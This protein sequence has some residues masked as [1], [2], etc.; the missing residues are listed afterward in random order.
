MGVLDTVTIYQGFRVY[1]D[2]SSWCPWSPRRDLGL[3]CVGRFRVRKGLLAT[4][5]PILSSVGI[6]EN[7][8]RLATYGQILAIHHVHNVGSNLRVGKR[9]HERRVLHFPECSKLVD[10]SKFLQ[11]TKQNRSSIKALSRSNST[12]HICGIRRSSI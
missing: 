2:N 3:V 12:D 8:I 6:P 10:L 7:K 11:S 9:D 4:G 1:W 5:S